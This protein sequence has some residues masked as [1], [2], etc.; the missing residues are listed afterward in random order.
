MKGWPVHERIELPHT[1]PRTGHRVY[2]TTGFDR[3]EIVDLCVL[4]NSVG[5]EPDATKWPPCLGGLCV[6]QL[7]KVEPDRRFEGV[8]EGF[9]GPPVVRK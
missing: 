6:S 7:E 4:I 5:R 1:V 2:F 3:E 8:P 9:E